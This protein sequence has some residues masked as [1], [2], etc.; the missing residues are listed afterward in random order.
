MLSDTH[1]PNLTIYSSSK[2]VCGEF[3]PKTVQKMAPA[4]K[5]VQYYMCPWHFH[6]LPKTDGVA[7]Q[8]HPRNDIFHP[9][10]CHCTKY[11]PFPEASVEC[12]KHTGGETP[13]NPIN[14]TPKNKKDVLFQ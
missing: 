8:D 10:H 2:F 13:E 7:D 9:N 6:S 5:K 12:L 4:A 1:T 11:S 14:P 3:E